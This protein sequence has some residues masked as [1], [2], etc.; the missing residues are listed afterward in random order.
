MQNKVIFNIALVIA[1]LTQVWFLRELI[2][3]TWAWFSNPEAMTNSM[4]L[5]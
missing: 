4:Q 3:A 1:T 5:G 2:S